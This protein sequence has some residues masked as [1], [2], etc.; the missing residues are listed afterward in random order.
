MEI[1]DIRMPE[2]IDFEDLHV[3]D[4]FVEKGFEKGI[5]LRVSDFVSCGTNFNSIC[6]NAFCP[7]SFN[8]ENKV[9]VLKATLTIE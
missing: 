3:G 8:K 6:L 4:V 1:E 5:Y 9:K 2:Y 7:V